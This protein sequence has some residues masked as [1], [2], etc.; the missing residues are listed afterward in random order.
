[1]SSMTNYGYNA[2]IFVFLLPTS[3]GFEIGFYLITQI[4]HKSTRK[5]I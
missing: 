4:V 5:N 1:M 2:G 3:V